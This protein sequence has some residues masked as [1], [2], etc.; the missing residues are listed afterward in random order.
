MFRIGD[1][2][3]Q[4]GREFEVILGRIKIAGSHV[5]C[6]KNRHSSTIG[7]KR[8]NVLLRCQQDQ[9]EKNMKIRTNNQLSSR[10]NANFQTFSGFRHLGVEQVG[11]GRLNPSVQAR[12]WQYSGGN[13]AGKQAAVENSVGSLDVVCNEQLC[14]KWRWKIPSAFPPSQ[15]KIAVPWRD[16]FASV[17]WPDSGE[18]FM[19]NSSTI[20]RC[21][22]AIDGMKPHSIKRSTH[23]EF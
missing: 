21:R 4:F 13:D 18:S 7:P 2:V 20:H 23:Y 16:R 6:G 1:S 3:G 15:T 12:P 22:S 10:R 5:W 8:Q 14:G 9:A 17:R 11:S 19:P